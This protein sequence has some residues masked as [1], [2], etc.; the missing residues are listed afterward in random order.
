MT[1]H[2]PPFHEPFGNE[3]ARFEH[4]FRERLPLFI[5]GPTGCEEKAT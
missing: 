2:A 5:K 1:G 3:I 4:A